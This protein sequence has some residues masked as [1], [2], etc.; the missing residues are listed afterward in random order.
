MVREDKIHNQFEGRLRDI[1]GL[2]DIKVTHPRWTVYYMDGVACEADLVGED[3]DGRLYAFQV[4]L[5]NNPDMDDLIIHLIKYRCGVNYSYAILEEKFCF[6]NLK[7]IFTINGLGLIT[8]KLKKGE[9]DNV[10]KEIS[11]TFSKPTY[12]AK[13]KSASF[14]DFVKLPSVYV[15]PHATTEFETEYALRKRLIE[16]NKDKNDWYNHT[17]LYNCAPGSI[18]LFVYKKKIVGEGI[19]RQYDAKAGKGYRRRY[20]FVPKSM[21]LFMPSI[22]CKDTVLEGYTNVYPEL[23]LSQ[24]FELLSK[25]AGARNNALGN[26][27]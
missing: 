4:K 17:T 20:F 7:N 22:S 16:I 19:I 26:S 5:G 25:L 24:Y 9:V 1:F 13:T 15:F 14:D 11:A 10:K 2:V 27:R 21:R 12:S 23:D 6:D 8:F 18:A 3:R